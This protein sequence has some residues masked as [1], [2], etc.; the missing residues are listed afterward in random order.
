MRELGAAGV[1]RDALFLAWDF[2]IASSRNLTERV[3]HI[4]DE[5]FAALG[6]SDLTDNMVSGVAPSF[7]ITKVEDSATDATMRHIEGTI[8]VPN[9]LTPQLEVKSPLPPVELPPEVAAALKPLTSALPVGLHDLQSNAFAVPGSRFNQL[10]SDSSLPSVDPL[11]PTVE[12]PF[13]CDIARGSDVEPSHP[14]LYGHGLLGS[15]TE[16]D[17][18]STQRLRERGFSPCAVD[19][20]GFSF[21]DLPSV[22]GALVDLSAFPSIIDRSQQG[23]LNFLLLGRA[24]SNPAGLSSS[25]AFRTADG[26]PLLRTNELAYDGNSQGAIMG[27]AL[28]ALAPDFR[29]AVLGVPGMGYST[30][31]NRSTDWEDR[32]AAIYQATYPNPVDQQIG[33]ALIQMLW[34]RGEASGYAQ[35][36]TAHPLPNTPTHD[37]MLQVAFGDHQVANATAEI[38]ARTIG[39]S[40]KVPALAPGQHWSIDPAFGFT[41]SSG[42]T[43]NVGSVLVYWFAADTG[44]ATPPNGNTPARAG[45]DPHSVPRSYG[46]ATDQVARFLLTGDLIDVCGG[47]PCV[48]PRG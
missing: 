4:R 28:T 2:T 48:V 42:D 41:T 13:L 32:Y 23:F 6:D 7:A 31:L 16:A 21:A 35:Q 37:V 10:G 18:G 14:V 38:E 46:P 26:R 17:G 40:L 11:Q 8:A 27:G 39:A 20:W 43:P 30:L 44:L 9:Y 3:L 45:T 22:A 47:A 19:W 25:S 33:F 29:R 36:M 1:E 34:D 5:A 12:V 15:R 24:L